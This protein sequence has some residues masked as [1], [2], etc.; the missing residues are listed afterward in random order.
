[1]TPAPDPK[2]SSPTHQ[3]E[4]SFVKILSPLPFF[5]RCLLSKRSNATVK[6]VSVVCL[7][8]L[9]VSFGSLVIVFSIMD[10]LG[11]SIKEKFLNHEPHITV[12]L[13]PTQSPSPLVHQNK[14][15]KILNNKNL[16]SSLKDFYFFETVDVI[17]RSKEG[18]FAGAVAKGFN[19]L[20]FQKMLHSL[21]LRTMSL[22]SPLQSLDHSSPPPPP[23][24]EAPP[25]SKNISLL[26]NPKL[27][28]FVHN[29]PLV[30][31]K[32]ALPSAPVL[33]GE[34]LAYELQ[35]Y[36]GEGL[37]LFP[38]ESFLLPPGEPIRFQTAKLQNV[39]SSHNE[40]FNSSFVFYNTEDFPTFRQKSSYQAGFEVYLKHPHRYPAYRQAL[41][42]GGYL[43][44]TWPEK[45]S[46]I[47][48]ALKIEKTIMSLFLSI[49]GFSTLL[50][51]SCL[52]VL[53]IVQKKKEMGMLLA[54]GLPLKKIQT[55][56]VKVGLLLCG[57]G[58]SG[59]IA[60]GC[61][62][63]L[64]L[65]LTP[66]PFLYAFFPEGRVPVE[67][68]WPFILL[69][70]MGG[71]GFAALSSWLSVKSQTRFSPAGILKSTV[72]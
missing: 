38:A 4:G 51:V 37:D 33:V 72:R 8:G 43:S 34:D 24:G 19:P 46:S 23:P 28:Q 41:Q 26:S 44:E 52:L 31:N 21:H 65:K 59:G 32:K 17:L 69:M 39:F 20:Q 42:D 70:T 6:R 60:F 40:S 62:V 47:F 9:V 66:L 48:Y 36:M 5:Q 22:T 49:A 67:L 57:L 27:Y 45:N 18:R 14:I 61:L 15:L 25:L 2:T 50:A 58:L 11:F 13:D 64:I 53:L 12:F 3:A 7:F 56:F 63:C 35:I 68:N 10:G 29:S 71:L 1:M 54:M 55:L 16:P 30:K